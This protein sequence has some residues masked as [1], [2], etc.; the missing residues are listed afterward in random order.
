MVTRE[1]EEYAGHRRVSNESES[2]EDGRAP[3]KNPK[4]TVK[5]Q[6]RTGIDGETFVVQD[7]IIIVKGK[8]RPRVIYLLNRLTW[9]RNSQEVLNTNLEER[10]VDI[11]QT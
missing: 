2:R 10:R 4:V 1:I 7:D 8:T 11:S 3:T 9:E 5:A 6:I